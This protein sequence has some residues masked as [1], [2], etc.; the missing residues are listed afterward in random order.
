MNLETHI[1]S[2]LK[3]VGTLIKP[4]MNMSIYKGNYSCSCSETH[5]FTKIET[6][7]LAEGKM[8][9]ISECPNYRNYITA[10]KLKH[11]FL[12]FKGFDTVCGY[13]FENNEEYQS[14]LYMLSNLR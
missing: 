6:K 5:Y 4:R 12:K 7:I 11:F 10:L 14:F 3:K 1:E 9:I 2:F 8:L 13:K